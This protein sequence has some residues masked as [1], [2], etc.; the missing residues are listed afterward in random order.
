[1]EVMIQAPFRW[2]QDDRIGDD[3]ESPYYLV[4]RVVSENTA[5]M[6]VVKK[7]KLPSK[8]PKEE[9]FVKSQHHSKQ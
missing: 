1:M 6:N 4:Y 5:K 8:D 2:V 7:V 9:G 3:P